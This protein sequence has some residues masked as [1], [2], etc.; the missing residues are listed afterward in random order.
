M[1][2][3]HENIV[4]E[5]KEAADVTLMQTER[6]W[7]FYPIQIYFVS[8]NKVSPMKKSFILFFITTDRA[9]IGKSLSLC[10]CVAKN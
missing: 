6:R 10:V 7:D 1:Y 4:W 3:E 9:A 8:L 2:L 5:K